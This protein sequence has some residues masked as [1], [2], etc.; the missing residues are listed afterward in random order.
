[1]YSV[2]LVCFCARE[3][4]R[5]ICILYN[6]E[7][8]PFENRWFSDFETGTIGFGGQE[9]GKSRTGARQERAF[10]TKAI[11]SIT[12]QPS[13]R[14]TDGRTDGRTHA[15]IERTHLKIP[16]IRASD[17]KVNLI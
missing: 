2:N 3:S 15:L 14:W 6:F 13:D 12:D 5:L 16:D 9:Q 8:W 4:F 1:M 11:Q 7:A 17:L 10:F